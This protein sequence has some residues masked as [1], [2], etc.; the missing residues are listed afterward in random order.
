MLAT[1]VSSQYHYKTYMHY[2][3]D[4]KTLDDSSKWAVLS[5]FQMPMCP[6]KRLHFKI[7]LTINSLRNQPKFATP[8]QR[9][10]SQRNDVWGMRAEIPHWWYLTTQIW[11]VILTGWR[12][13]PS[14]HDKSVVQTNLGSDMSSAWSF[15][16][17][18]SHLIS[19]R[20]QWWLRKMLAV[21]S[22]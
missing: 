19:Q 5:I 10:V 2:S 14:W 21:F 12:K 15:R 13:F 17:R 22:S 4:R 9:L 1:Q 6:A 7:K 16:T 18:S 20:N 11:T 8:L 3:A